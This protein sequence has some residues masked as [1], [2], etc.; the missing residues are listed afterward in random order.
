MKSKDIVITSKKMIESNQ[1]DINGLA[2]DFSDTTFW[3][4]TTL[5]TAKL[6]LKNKCFYV[7]NLTN[8]NDKAEADNHKMTANSIYALCFCN[9]K[10]EKI[11]MWYLYSGLT[12]RGVSI[13]ITP[14]VML[15]FIRSIE[16][17]QGVND[18]AQYLRNKD[19]DLSAAWV[20]YREQ[21][22][23]RVI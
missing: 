2:K 20:Y 19:F 3:Y 4:Y 13:G 16:N 9:S 8:M 12:G 18:N 14:A 22:T 23:N 11:P 10:S 5:E 1:I 7:N 21:K 17:V 15:E 6:I